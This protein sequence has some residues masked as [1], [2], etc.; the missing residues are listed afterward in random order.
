[1]ATYSDNC[2]VWCNEGRVWVQR[3]ARSMLYIATRLYGVSWKG[4]GWESNMKD[5]VMA[6]SLGT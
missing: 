3:V 4:N 2:L 6:R 5:Y 1:V